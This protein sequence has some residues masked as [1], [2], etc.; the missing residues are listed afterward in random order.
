MRHMLLRLG[1]VESG[2][3]REVSTPD[4]QP[5]ACRT[6]VIRLIKG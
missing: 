3:K 2:P 5:G 6:S 1:Y 4:P